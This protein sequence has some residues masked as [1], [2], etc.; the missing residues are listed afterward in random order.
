MKRA[1]KFG[2]Q[3]FA[4][5]AL[6]LSARAE[7]PLAD[8]VQKQDRAAIQSLL[9]KPEVNST[10]IDGSTPLHWAAQLEDIVTTKALLKLGADPKATNRYG[11]APITLAA[12]VG[13]GEIIELLLAAGADAN[14][15]DRTGETPLML[16]AR[17]GKPAAVKSL[18]ARGADVNAKEKKGQTALMWAAAEG[19]TEVVDLLLKAGAD[20]KT[21]LDSG[22]TPLLF[23]I[24]E[25]RADVAKLLIKAGA[26]VN[27]ATQAKRKASRGPQAGMTPLLMAVENGHFELA[28]DLIKA[29]ADPNDQ[30][31]GYTALHN[32][33]WVR[34]PNKGEDEDGAPPPDGSGKLT[35]IQFVRQLVALGA[36]VNAK[37][38]RGSGGKNAVSLNGATPFLM[39]AKTADKELCSLLLELGADSFTTNVDGDTALI[40]CAGL[41]TPTADEVAGTEEECV[42]TVEWLLKIGLDPNAVDKNGE[43][44]MHG[45]AY[46]NLPKVIEYLAAHGAKIEV[47]NKKNKWGWTPLLIAQGF[48]PGNF[49]PSFETIAAI[50]KVMLAEGVTPPPAPTSK[51]INNTDYVP[52][53]VVQKTTQ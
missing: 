15:T 22:F 2:V 53:K 7:S 45:A 31:G 5:M 41:G 8:A 46:K 28:I 16:A 24:R 38:S 47:W 35:S 19:N 6:I 20:F 27:E 14:L 34:K 9:K 36:D 23:A 51:N 3:A 4:C 50:E 18:L 37:I 48:R 25:G 39:A 12:R 42:E 40:A 44:A 17:T 13:N 29:G 21:P 52:K 1:A 30:R 10:Q 11:I 49:K 43:T 33:V 26:D 32:I